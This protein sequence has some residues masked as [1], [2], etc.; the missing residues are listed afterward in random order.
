MIRLTF[1]SVYKVSCCLV[2]VAQF[3]SSVAVRHRFRLKYEYKKIC[4]DDRSEK[5]RKV[6]E[7]KTVKLL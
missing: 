6:F 1:G 3:C 5:M 7:S 4:F 2:T